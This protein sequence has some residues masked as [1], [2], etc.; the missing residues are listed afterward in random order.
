MVNKV[1]FKAIHSNN[2]KVKKMKKMKSIMKL[3]GKFA[4]IFVGIDQRDLMTITQ[5]RIFMSVY[6]KGCWMH[7]KHG[8]KIFKIDK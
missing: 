1:E 3:V 2:E 8:K 6:H 7:K 4:R 5:Q